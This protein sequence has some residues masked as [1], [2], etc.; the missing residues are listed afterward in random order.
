MSANDLLVELLR[1]GVK[2]WSECGRLGVSAPKGAL[3]ADLRAALTLHRDELLALLGATNRPGDEDALPALVHAPES[4]HDPFPLTELQ[5]AYWVGRSGVVELSTAI[6]SYTEIESESIDLERLSRAWQTIVNRHEMLRA[7]ALPAGEQQILRSVPPYEI[8]VEDLRGQPHD[9]VAAHLVDTRDRLSHRVFPLQ[10]WPLFELRALR[11]DGGVIRVC[12]SIDCTFVDAWSLQILFRELVQSYHQSERALEPEPLEL[13]F[14]DYVLAIG[15]LPETKAYQRS[16]AFWRER[17]ARLPHAPELPLAKN[18]ASITRPRYRRWVDRLDRAL[19]DE[20]KNQARRRGLTPPGLLLAAYAE[21]LAGW[22]R[23]P[24]F[25]LNVPLYNRL[26]LHPHVDDVVGTFSSF[27]LVEVDPRGKQSFLERAQAIQH[28]LWEALENRFVSGVQILRQMFQRQGQISGAL[29]PVVF[30]SFPNGVSGRDSYWMDFLDRELGKVVFSVTQT[31]QV[32]ID[33]QV[34]YQDG[35]VF[36]NWDAVEDLFPPGMLDVMFSAYCRL[37]RRLAADD[38]VWEERTI[39]LAPSAQDALA[40]MVPEPLRDDALLQNLFLEQ[41]AHRPDDV[42]VISSKRRLTYRELSERAH[43]LARVLRRGGARPNHPV[44]IIME[45]G[46]E[47]VVAALATLVAGAPYMPIDPEVPR[48]RLGQLIESGEVEQILTQS[49]LDAKLPWPDNVVRIPVDHD[50]IEDHA[51]LD[52]RQTPDHLAFIIYTSG[53]NGVPSGAMLAHRGVVNAILETNRHFN[54]G[55]S[56]RVLALT[57]LHHDMSVYDIFGILAAGGALVIPDAASRRDPSHWWSLIA[58]EHVT[59]WNSVPAMMEMLVVYATGRNDTPL[60]SLRL[61]FLGGDWIPVSL[62]ERLRAFAPDI[63][64]VSV[65]GP[66]ETTLWNIWYRIGDVDPNWKSI[67][68]GRAIANT[69]YYVMSDALEERPVWVA[70]ELCCAGVGVAKGYWRDEE[71]TRTKFVA[72]PTTGE[73]L[74]RTGDLGR[75]LPDGNIE[76]LGRVDNQLSV[77]G[78]RIE[79][80]EIE[81]ALASHSDVE[82]AVVVATGEHHEKRLVAW[83]IARGDRARDDSLKTWLQDRLPQH[84]VP[85]LYRFVDRFPLNAN[86]KVDR[87]ALADRAVADPIAPRPMWRPDVEEKLVRL[88]REVLNVSDIPTEKNFFDLGANSLHLVRLHARIQRELGIE[89]PVIDMFQHPNIAYLAQHLSRGAEAP[90]A[91]A[92]RV[93]KRARDATSSS[94]AIVGMSCRFPGASNIDEFWRNLAGGVESVSFFSDDELAAAGVDPSVFRDSKY[95]RAGAILKDIDLFDAAFFGFNAKEAQTQDPQHRIFL[96]CAVEALENAGVNPQDDDT[97]IGV[98]AGKSMSTYVYPVLDLAQPL[99]YFQMLFANDKDFLTTHLSYRLNLKGPSVNV[100]TACSTSLVAVAMACR[101]LQSGE[102][103]VALAGGVA[104]KIPQRAGFLSEDGTGIFSSDG[105][106]RPFDARGDGIIPGSGAGV[107][108][109][110]RLEDALADRDSI[111]AVIRGWAMNNDGAR[112]V[113]FTAPSVEAQADVIAAA[114]ALAGVDAESVTYIEA[115]GTGTPLGDPI[116][117]A[118]LTQAFR[119]STQKKRFCAVGSVKSNFG[120]LDSAAGVAGLIKTVLALENRKLPPSL[121]FEQPNPKIDFENSAFYVNSE[122][123]DWISDGAPRRA[124]VSSFGVG[125]TN[126]HVV[127]EEAPE[128]P[129][130][131]DDLPQRPWHVLTLSAKSERAL[132]ELAQRYAVALDGNADL[133]DVCYSTNTGRSAFEHRLAATA[134]TSEEMRRQLEGFA[135]GAKSPR[136]TS[137]RVAKP[138]VAFLFTGQGS[139]YAGMGRQL[140]E[141]ERVFRQAL[142]RCDQALRP[143]LGRSLLDDLDLG[144]L[145]FSQPMIFSLEYALAELWRSWNV[146]PAAVIGHS[147]GEYAAACIAGVFSVED[148]LTLVAARGRLFDEL[149]LEGAMLAVHAG[150]DRVRELLT[151]EASLA[152]I[153]SPS[154]VVVSGTR[155]AIDAAIAALQAIDVR[156]EMISASRA[157]HSPLVDPLLDPF[158]RVA[159]GI[160]YSMPTMEVISNLAGRPAGPEIATPEYWRRHLREPVRFADGIATLAGKGYETFVE[161]GPRPDLL[162]A[163]RQCITDRSAALLPSLRQGR[164]DWQS[165]LQSLGA[166]FVRGVPVDWRALDRDHQRRKVP[167]PTYPFQRQRY[168]I[169]ATAPSPRPAT[170]HASAA[171]RLLGQRVR[172]AALKQGEV[173]FESEIGEHSPEFIADH[174]ID[175]VAILPATAYLEMAVAAGREVF[176]TEEVSLEGVGIERA[177]DFRPGEL[178][179]VQLLMRPQD[180]GGY[181]FEIFSDGDSEWILHCSGSV[182]AASSLSADEPTLDS[183]RAHAGEELRVEDHYAMAAA[184]GVHF[185]PRF[186][187][188]EQMWRCENGGLLRVRRPALVAA[189]RDGYVIHPAVFDAC[190]QGISVALPPSNGDSADVP[191]GVERM[192]IKGRAGDVVWSQI[193]TRTG[194]PNNLLCDVRLFSEDGTS[195]AFV[196]GLSI[197]RVRRTALTTAPLDHL[198]AV[199]WIAAPHGSTATEPGIVLVE[200]DCGR[201]LETVQSLLATTPMPGLCIVTREAQPVGANAS[202]PGLT[203]S[204]VWGLARVI[205]REHP[206]LRC[207]RIDLDAHTP[208]DEVLDYLPNGEDEVAFRNG[209]F[210]IPRLR[211]SGERASRPQ[212]SDVSAGGYVLITGGLGGLGL[213]AAE[214]LVERGTRHLI[215]LSRSAPSQQAT[216]RI[217]ALRARNATILTEQAD[218]ANENAL[219]E[220]LQR[221]E[222]LRGIIHAAGIIDD[223]VI[224]HQT[225]ERFAAV[226]APKV[227]GAWNLHRLTEQAPLDFFIMFSSAVSLLGTEGQSSYA[228]ANAYLDALAHHRRAKGLPALSINWGAWTGVHPEREARLQDLRHRAGL[229]SI[230]APAAFATFD[231]VFAIPAPQ[232]AVLP[233]DWNRF[234]SQMRPAPFFSDVIPARDAEPR[235]FLRRLDAAPPAQKR[236]LLAA[237]V[238]QQVATVLGLDSPAAVRMSQGLFEMG[239]DS[240]GSLELRSLLENSLGLSLPSTLAFNYP[241]VDALVAHLNDALRVPAAPLGDPT[242]AIANRLASKLASME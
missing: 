79:P 94:I 71:K 145:T 100:V 160:R 131:R 182:T 199:E 35:G 219:S 26:P 103:E 4:R 82:S 101:S 112:K 99:N 142:D 198:Y 8:E 197:R 171:H 34:L 11:L 130:A 163:V 70:G 28:Q 149:A 155:R 180:G 215:L 97:T 25:T 42:A 36:F 161:I 47:Q 93:R 166:L 68:Y 135:S 44:A 66:T 78:H 67:P 77:L 60:S 128:L 55:A 132:Q 46:W 170:A 120:H 228:A 37:L 62:P 24:H 22:T 234:L 213:L 127:L 87:R 113:G 181:R 110:K 159:R 150:E 237:Q 158:E 202:V 30:T 204:P 86:G 73:R 230:D 217:E 89:I 183:L 81:A 125:G 153:N 33:H 88:V 242:A 76:F 177:M 98:F 53:S 190:L 69:K 167:L 74:Y 233:I 84:M 7:I 231:R 102:C 222:K 193:Q 121:N 52:A 59:V 240:L 10:Q 31:P 134:R 129:A 105:H 19:W 15:K 212:P 168:W 220:V 152:S 178:K 207:I 206:E 107:V 18:P 72:H 16:L 9:L 29:M 3:T 85:A 109:L 1:V 63:E 162:P 40:P 141:T 224:E 200:P 138:R 108:V 38:G 187:G 43:R 210:Y 27:T 227:K 137:G 126:A 119:L 175:N 139:Q 185:G 188:I 201:V 13:S 151:P 144:S 196:E 225:R 216:D 186:R 106:C 80:G 157:A 146:Q 154:N 56:D 156:T 116:E 241:T 58:R 45:K 148:A 115:H 239:L 124:G 48:E 164:D 117:I 12:I 90:S 195:V 104:V 64:L 218:V 203:Q 14:R 95:V 5:Q 176:R 54:I 192:S 221:I 173:L 49:W 232:V 114:Q 235:E 123:R 236:N 191:V 91:P 75:M 118:A 140:Y 223:G 122:L 136:V 143:Q 21:V 169:D 39:A 214:W 57:A 83:V 147:L 51:P 92:R 172:S 229:G 208:I 209:T 184:R 23:S 165:I 189:E 194:A 238:R 205:A 111:R 179:K 61:A 226:L 65:G 133:A 20:L 2:L 174:S 6:H 50:V 17:V 41:A 32:W 96:E 211:R